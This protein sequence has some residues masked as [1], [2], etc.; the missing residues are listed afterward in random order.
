MIPN[1][2]QRPIS[3]V[4]VFLFD[5]KLISAFSGFYFAVGALRR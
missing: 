4:V 3:T 1:G 5:K 2:I